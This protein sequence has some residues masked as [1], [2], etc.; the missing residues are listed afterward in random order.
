MTTI[1]VKNIPTD[2]YADLK[3]SAEAHRRSINSEIIFCIERAVRSRKVSP[4]E[5]V[6][7]V[8]ILRERTARYPV[9]DEAFTQ[10]KTDGRA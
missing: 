6:A 10:A 9:S 7:R 2:L 1:T 3:R 4:D 5:V 8:R